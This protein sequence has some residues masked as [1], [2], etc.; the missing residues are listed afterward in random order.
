MNK[1]SHFKSHP[2]KLKALVLEDDLSRRYKSFQDECSILYST[3][4][5]NR[6]SFV[7][8]IKPLI[9]VYVSKNISIS[10]VPF[11]ASTPKLPRLKKLKLKRYSPLTSDQFKSVLQRHRCTLNNLEHTK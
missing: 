8:K 1:N 7:K 2:K 3:R 11:K 6:S 4:R 10:P 9:K 5:G